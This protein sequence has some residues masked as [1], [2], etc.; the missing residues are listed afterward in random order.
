MGEPLAAIGFAQDQIVGDGR[1]VGVEVDDPDRL[2]IDEADD[3]VVPLPFEPRDL[4]A[5]DVQP[6]DAR[7]VQVD[8]IAGH[9]ADRTG[10][11]RDHL[12]VHHRLPDTGRHLRRS[13]ESAR[14]SIYRDHEPAARCL[15]A[16][17]PLPEP[18]P[19]VAEIPGPSLAGIAAAP[20]DEDR[21]TYGTGLSDGSRGRISAAAGIAGAA[22]GTARPLSAGEGRASPPRQ[23]L[24][25][26]PCG[27]RPGAAGAAVVVD[28]PSRAVARRVG[29][30]PGLTRSSTR[31]DPAPSNPIRHDCCLTSWP[32]RWQ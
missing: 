30:R 25:Q 5:G 31:P 27:H 14:C 28:D 32:Q 11:L 4:C 3:E 8:R 13:H 9:V 19:V 22:H 26:S 17:I 12:H 2:A 18:I 10:R 21:R 23:R 24:C 1:L 7:R 29:V 6:N 15:A 20:G 16:W